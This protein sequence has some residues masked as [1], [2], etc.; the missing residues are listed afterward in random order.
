MRRTGAAQLYAQWR[1]LL[2]STGLADALNLERLV[3][4]RKAAPCGAANNQVANPLVI[5]LS[6]RAAMATDQELASVRIVGIRA[7]DKRIKRI[8]SMDEIGLYQEIER[9]VYGGRRG[10]TA[11]VFECRQNLVG[12]YRFMAV[13]NELQD[14][15]TLGG[16]AKSAFAADPLSSLYSSL[17]TSSVIVF[18]RGK[19][20]GR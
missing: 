16:Q 8:Q 13:P 15:T 7:T 12:A 4:S 3:R 6:H 20:A 11:I 1:V 10:I 19:P 14:A 2:G 5:Q 17:D 18:V 9:P